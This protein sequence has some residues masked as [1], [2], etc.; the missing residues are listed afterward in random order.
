MILKTMD[1]PGT[2]GGWGQSQAVPVRRDAAGPGFAEE[3]TRMELKTIDHQ[4]T[5]CKVTEISSIDLDADL[6][7]IGKTDEELSLVCKTED[8][9]QN[10]V[11]REDGWRGFRIQGVLDFSLIGILSKLS[12]ILAEHQIGIFAVSTYNT[13]YILVKEEN[14]ERALDV[15]ASEGYIVTGH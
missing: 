2:G 13:D 14:Y 10:T 5:V 9:P 8:T 15:L 12:G 6:Y 1:D 4:L 11:E 7:F 3:K